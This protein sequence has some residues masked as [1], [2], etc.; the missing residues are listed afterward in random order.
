MAGGS[1]NNR[2]G[3]ASLTLLVTWEV[4]N[5]RNARV[6]RNKSAPSG[7]VID[8]IRNEAR[9]WVLAGAKRLGNIMPGE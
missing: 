9:L 7:F 8:K 6:F 2:K 4:W 1:S 5:E 3:F